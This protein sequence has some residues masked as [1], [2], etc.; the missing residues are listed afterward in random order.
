MAI[1]FDAVSSGAGNTGTSYTL[2]HTCTGTDLW[3]VVMA[4]R[5]GAGAIVLTATYNGVAMSQLW[6]VAAHKRVFGL[7]APATGANNIVITSDSDPDE[8]L[9]VAA[10]YT[11]VHQTT[12]YTDLT[13]DV[14]VT[15][16]PSISV[17]SAAGDVVV[18]GCFTAHNTSALT[19]TAGADQ[20]ER[21]DAAG[22]GVNYMSTTIS[23]EAGAGSVTHSYTVS[24][25]PFYDSDIWGVSVNPA[26]AA[27]TSGAGI[28]RGLI[29][30]GT[31]A[32]INAGL[33]RRQMAKLNEWVERKS[34][35]WVPK[36]ARTLV[37]VAIQLQGA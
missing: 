11:G 14:T 12:P 32:G 33:I 35:L 4:Q 9:V 29:N 5:W 31:N 8:I 7:V 19:F 34:G 24:A 18:G 27:A 3:L 6:Y 36:D 16:T 15:A 28:G 13:T 17:P 30:G 21:V 23:D 22:S 1:A 37:P 2:A 25:T 10:S 20:T 26:A